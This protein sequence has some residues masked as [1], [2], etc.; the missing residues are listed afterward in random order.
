VL[1]RLRWDTDAVDQGLFGDPRWCVGGSGERVGAGGCFEA[2]RVGGECCRA[3]LR[4]WPAVRGGP[5]GWVS[6]S[7]GAW[8]FGPGWF[9]CL[10]GRGGL[11]RYRSSRGRRARAWAGLVKCGWVGCGG[12]K[13]GTALV[14]SRGARA[15][16]ASHAGWAP[17]LV[18]RT[19]D[20][21]CRETYPLIAETCVPRVRF[22]RA[23]ARRRRRRCPADAVT[24]A[25]A[26]AVVV[27][28][29]AGAGGCGLRGADGWCGDGGDLAG[30]GD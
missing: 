19:P 21:H 22:L 1:E 2:A 16:W 20:G 8:S 12:R 14:G 24:S 11:R 29:A 3:A 15:G 6:W 26:G 30:A 27:A 13:L 9:R 4:R 17:S 23:G 28:S 10:G 5:P 18:G 7:G 25:G